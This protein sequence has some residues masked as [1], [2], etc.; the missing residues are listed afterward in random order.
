MDKHYY[1]AQ[2]LNSIA[3]EHAR[4]A[5]HLLVDKQQEGNDSLFAVTSLMVIAHKLLLDSCFMQAGN[6]NPQR[7]TF[8]ELIDNSTE[9]LNKHEAQLLKY[10][11]QQAA[12]QKGLDYELWED[13]QQFT[14]F[15]HEIITLFNTLQKRIPIELDDLYY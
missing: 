3:R 7:K 6:T 5:E 14:V 13:G 8:N 9:L 12:F 1:S 4:C 11:N 10:L 15:C 2:Q